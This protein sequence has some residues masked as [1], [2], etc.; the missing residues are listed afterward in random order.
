MKAHILYVE[1]DESLSFVTRD[2]LELQGYKI[3]HC[4][5]GRDALKKVG[6][7]DFDLCILDVMLPEVDGF[8]VAREIRQYNTDIPI[9]FLTAKSLKEDRLY[10]LRLGADDYI[11]KPF[12]IE[13]L[14]LKVEVFLRRSKVGAPKPPGRYRL[15]RF[16]LDHENLSLL[17]GE[18]RLQL[19]QK[20]ADLLK[21]FA[22]NPNQVLKRSDILKQIWG[23]DD[24]FLG[25]SLDVFISRL[26]KYL[27]ADDT[28]K[29]ENIHGVGFRLKSE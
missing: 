24:Y 2:N 7:Q 28:L 29:V 12:S 8:T 18:E 9:L 3:T 6:E 10:G 15:G 14:I 20:E 25:R 23:D 16:E 19:T 4:T 5:D 26:R 1:D 21:L 27:R 17:H 22:E 11:T 13:E